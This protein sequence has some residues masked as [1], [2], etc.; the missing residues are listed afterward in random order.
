MHLYSILEIKAIPEASHFTV[1]LPKI[2][3]T[4][5]VHLF[6]NQNDF[7]LDTG[8]SISK[9]ITSCTMRN[10]KLNLNLEQDA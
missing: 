9:P 3:T 8:P 6:T 1:S 5:P 4:V 2:I 10:M 7:K